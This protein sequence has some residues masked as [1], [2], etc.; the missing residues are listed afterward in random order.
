MGGEQKC[1]GFYKM[2]RL[3]KNSLTLYGNWIDFK[4]EFKEVVNDLW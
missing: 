3:K 4:V 1:R 2:A